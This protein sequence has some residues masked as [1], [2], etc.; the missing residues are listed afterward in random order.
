MLIRLRHIYNFLL[1]HA[2]I[3]QLL[4]TFDNFLYDLFG[5]TNLSS[6]Q[7]QFMFVACFCIA[8]NPYKTK[9][10]HVATPWRIILEYL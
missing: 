1:F 4:H 5:L 2:N 9:S 3:I 8:E 7:C 10:K 6:A